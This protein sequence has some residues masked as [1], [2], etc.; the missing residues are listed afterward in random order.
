MIIGAR[1]QVGQM[2]VSITDPEGSVGMVLGVT[3]WLGERPEHAPHYS[4]I[5]TWGGERVEH[6]GEE[7]TAALN[8]GRPINVTDLKDDEGVHR[9]R[10]DDADDD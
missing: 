9:Q 6:H 3:E 10:P 2:V 1:W 5:V 8:E 4:Y 7:L